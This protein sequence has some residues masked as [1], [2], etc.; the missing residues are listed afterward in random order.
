[1]FG[2]PTVGE[3]RGHG[4]HATA[5]SVSASR[6][7]APG[8]GTARH[9]ARRA[10]GRALFARGV[11]QTRRRDGRR[12]RRRAHPPGRARAG[13]DGAAHRDRRR[14]DLRAHGGAQPR[15][16]GRRRHDLRG[17][18]P[19]GRPHALRPLGLL[20]RRPGLGVL[21]RADRQRPRDDPRPRQA[22]PPQEGRP[23]RRAAARND[24]H[25]FLLRGLLLRR[26]G[27]LR[28]RSDPRDPRRPDRGRGLS[29]DVGQL[30]A[31]GSR[32]RPHV[33]LRL[34]RALRP[35]RAQPAPRPPARRR[36]RRRVRR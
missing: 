5:A 10:P 14:R 16:R 34:D 19:R 18:H 25:L 22:L 8:R 1:M 28:L 27:R 6:R 32:P 30:H 12:G 36:L 33:G 13:H 24:R 3:R 4:A 9:P 35:R 26:S 7:R 29:D 15:R 2:T 23:A 20:G 31:D 11:P 17:L 21:R